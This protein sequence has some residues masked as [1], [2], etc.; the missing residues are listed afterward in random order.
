[1]TI[2]FPSSVLSNLQIKEYMLALWNIPTRINH[3]T[4]TF[5]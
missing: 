2:A 3:T 5:W 1:M 4:R